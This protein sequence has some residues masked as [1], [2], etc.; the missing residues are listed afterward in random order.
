LSIAYFIQL[1]DSLM[2]ESG[3]LL[4]FNNILCLEFLE[5]FAFSFS[6]IL[7]LDKKT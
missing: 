7:F 4:K 2:F 5:L 1:V 3:Y 6:A